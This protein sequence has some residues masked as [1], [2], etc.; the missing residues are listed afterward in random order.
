MEEDLDHVPAVEGCLKI[1][2]HHVCNWKITGRR[3]VRIA[4]LCF[5]QSYLNPGMIY[6]KNFPYSDLL[7]I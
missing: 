5:H 1:S 6:G 7:S 3:R 4:N 2:L